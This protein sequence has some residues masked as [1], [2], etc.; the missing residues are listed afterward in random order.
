MA[1]SIDFIIIYSVPKE[2]LTESDL[3]GIY[4]IFVSRISKNDKFDYR[5]IIIIK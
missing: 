3:T 5:V 1:D 4:C 2:K